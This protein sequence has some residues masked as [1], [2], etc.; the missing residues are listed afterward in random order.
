VRSAER[1]VAV[2]T[3]DPIRDARW[4]DLVERHPR[5]SVFH[6]AAWLQALE[7]AYGYRALACTTSSPGER[8][9]NGVSFCDVRSWLTGRR[10]VS[11]PFADHCDPLVDSSADASAIAQQ[12]VSLAREGGQRYVEIRPISA[13]GWDAAEYRP[14]QTFAFQAIDLRPSLPELF[15]RL[16]V[17]GIQRKIRRAGRDGVVERQGRSDDLLRAFYQLLVATRRRHGAPP[18]P[19]RWFEA[20]RQ[21]FK[22]RLNVRLAFKDGHPIAAILTLVHRDTLVYK[23]GAS[24]AAHHRSGAMPFLMWNAIQEARQNEIRTFDLGRSDVDNTGLITFKERLG[25]KTTELTYLRFPAPR[26]GKSA[27][28]IGRVMRI[29]AQRLPDA[30]FVRAGAVLYKH[31]G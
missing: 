18:Q 19:M 24:D 29:V 1:A 6:T 7:V 16:H 3:L 12:L 4:S 20:L 8:L 25:A 15:E 2:F 26:P 23:Y 5:A 17:D 10:L 22:E 21:C 11:V 14:S 27:N 30:L 13:Q 31:M 28:P 9:E